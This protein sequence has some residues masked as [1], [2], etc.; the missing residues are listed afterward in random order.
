[1]FKAKVYSFF[2][3]D[4]EGRGIET[5]NVRNEIKKQ[6]IICNYPRVPPIVFARAEGFSRTTPA[7]IFRATCAG[8]REVASIIRS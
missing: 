1:M 3:H 7:I 2:I 6:I 8:E 4:S 5:N